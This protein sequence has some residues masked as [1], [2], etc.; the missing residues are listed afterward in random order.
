MNQ[1][2]ERPVLL[3]SFLFALMLIGGGAW[4]L[5]RSK[6]LFPALNPG[7]PVSIGTSIG[8]DRSLFSTPVSVAKQAGMDAFATGDY[9]RAKASFS[10]ALQK[11]RNDPETRI[12]LN[13]AKIGDGAAYTLAL[14]VPAS[15]AVKPALEMM[16]GVAQAQHTLN[17]AGGINGMP[18]KIR[19]L[20][21]EGNPDKAALIAKALVAAPEVLGVVGHFSSDTSLA[22]GK[23]Y[24]EGQ[25]TMVSP[26]S[27]AVE[28]ADLGEYVFRTVPSDRLAA[29]TLARHVLNQFKK[30]KVALFFASNSAYSLSIRSEFI[31]ELLSSGGS[32]VADFDIRQ[33]DFS[34]GQAVQTAKKQGA[35]AIMLALPLEQVTTALQVMSVNA[36]ALPM[37]GSDSLYIINVLDV[38]R[39][40][41]VGLTIAVPWH[42]LSH[43]ES[44]FVTESQKLWGGDINWRTATAYDATMALAQAIQANPTRAGV[45][46]V[47]GNSRFIAKGATDDVRFFTSGDRNQPSQLVEVQKGNRSGRGYD[48]VPVTIT[49]QTDIE[50]TAPKQTDEAQEQG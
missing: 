40:N 3:A 42:V 21:D 26:A 36:Q 49:K 48:F 6:Q 43:G 27:T 31:T 47:M 23:V 7:Q 38:G 13:N 24:E 9:E 41:A 39:N 22:A 28:L 19:V 33:P 37:V 2:N 20:D 5:I 16:R 12:Y 32:I 45:A 25:L 4:W 11:N 50:Q 1:P 46:E 18:L 35:E 29:G 15:K 17:E 10:E 34:P 44:P 8:S 14:S 30:K